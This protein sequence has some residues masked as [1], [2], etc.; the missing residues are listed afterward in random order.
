MDTSNLPRSLSACAPA[1]STGAH[2]VS[3]DATESA[4]PS[5]WITF[6]LDLLIATVVSG[7]LLIAYDRWVIRPARIVGVV[8]VGD[9]Y[10]Q[11]EAQFTTALTQATSDEERKKVL[12]TARQFSKELPLALEALPRDC[13][14]LVVL[15]SAIAAPA[16]HTMDLTA[17]LKHKLENAP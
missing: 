7:V 15:R 2:A 17:H 11:K 13:Q 6:F 5:M 3:M 8:D 9:I 1:D 4:R 14:C 10:R 16:P 12:E